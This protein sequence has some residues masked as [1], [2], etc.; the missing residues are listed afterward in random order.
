MSELVDTYA[1]PKTTGPWWERG[2]PG[3]PMVKVPGFPRPCYPPD[4]TQH[5]KKPSVD[6]PD[7]VAYKRTVSRAGRWAWAAFD[8]S[9]SNG[10][11]HGK[12]GNVGESGIA[13]VQRQQKIDATGWIGRKTFDTLRSIVIPEGL[14]HAGEM[15]MDATAAK[16]VEEAW[17][18]F[19]GHEPPQN[20]GTLRAARLERARSQLGVVESPAGSNH[21]KYGDWY[22]QDYQPWC[23]MFVTWCDAMAAGDI[24]KAQTALKRGERYA[25]VPYLV[26]DA[27]ANKY[28]LRV[29]DDPEPGNLVCYDWSPG[30]DGLFDHVGIF[31]AWVDS[32]GGFYA[33][34]GNTSSA[35]DSNGGRVERR[36][37]NRANQVTVFVRVPEP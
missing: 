3:G 14:P 6:G 8:D 36:T 32:K 30:G 24:G 37:R 7:I 11:A 15:A 23:A 17:Y 21:T 27:R 28:G 10:F 29:V 35:D 25:Y 4:A 19:E 13:G 5:G 16:L 34:E 12:S 2:Y 31:E 22:G 20:E 9:Y 26:G 18:L 1:E 33:I